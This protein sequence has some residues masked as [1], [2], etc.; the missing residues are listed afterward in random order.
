MQ[1]EKN[2]PQLEPSIWWN[3]SRIFQIWRL[4]FDQNEDISLSRDI[5]INPRK[6]IRGYGDRGRERWLASGRLGSLD[7][8]APCTRKVAA[9]QRYKGASQFCIKTIQLPR[10]YR[11]AGYRGPSRQ[12]DIWFRTR[13]RGREMSKLPSAAGAD[14]SVIYSIHPA[15]LVVFRIISPSPR[16][17]FGWLRRH[18]G[19]ADWIKKVL[20]GGGNWPP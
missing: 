17:W 8:P 15:Q 4:F 19:G 16:A 18:N 20:I 12:N 10:L 7:S 3:F 13:E 5:K 1:K 6:G 11:G 14:Q 9:G 2:D